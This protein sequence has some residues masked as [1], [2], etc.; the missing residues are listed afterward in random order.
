M[1]H[2][3]RSLRRQ[4]V[5]DCSES[6]QGLEPDRENWR[7]AFDLYLQAF[8]EPTSPIQQK[9]LARILKKQISQELQKDTFE[10]QA[11]LRGLGRMSLSELF[12]SYHTFSLIHYCL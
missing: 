4:I 1:S 12:G 5:T 10:Y 7:R 9:K 3:T 6:D 8:K 2:R 11:F